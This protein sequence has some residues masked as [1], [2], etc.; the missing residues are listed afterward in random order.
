[1][2]NNKK[3]RKV[4]D[5]MNK[6]NKAR[7]Y[8]INYI[9]ILDDL[10]LD[11][12]DVVDLDD[13][14][15]DFFVKLDTKERQRALCTVDYP[16]YGEFCNSDFFTRNKSPPTPI[17]SFED[18]CKIIFSSCYTGNSHWFEKIVRKYWKKKDLGKL[19]VRY[20]KDK[21]D[22]RR[23]K[24][25]TYRRQIE[26][27]LQKLKS[28]EA[29]DYEKRDLEKIQLKGARR[30]FIEL[31]GISIPPEVM[32][33]ILSYMPQNKQYLDN[34]GV[35]SVEFYLMCLKSWRKISLSCNNLYKIP[36]L[37]LRRVKYIVL[38]TR[39]L[40]KA[41]FLYFWKKT[42]S[43][44]VLR[45]RENAVKLF[46][47]LNVVKVNVKILGIENLSRVS[48]SKNY[49]PNIG[50]FS[51]NS[52]VLYE[53]EHINYRRAR[54][55]M[56][57][58]SSSGDTTVKYPIKPI[59]KLQKETRKFLESVNYITFRSDEHFPYR[60]CE[61]KFPVFLKK[62]KGFKHFR[63]GLSPEQANSNYWRHSASRFRKTEWWSCL[64][65]CK[66]LK[67][68]F[69]HDYNYMLMR[70]FIDSN[71]TAERVIINTGFNID[72]E[73]EYPSR[74]ARE[75]IQYLLSLNKLEF[76]K[77][78]VLNII[79]PS[80]RDIDKV[81]SYL[82]K[83]LENYTLKCSKKTENDFRSWKE[84]FTFISLDNKKT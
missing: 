21:D 19:L 52:F 42:R 37:V 26:V 49:F 5:R 79:Q 78:L 14:R 64:S 82:C 76:C 34:I 33:E 80:D 29:I 17:E 46:K 84:T 83:I 39:K 38:K 75:K 47:Y 12:V 18:I 11:A 8:R 43:V 30:I 77:I 22:A 24:Q 74:Y 23:L 25:M 59:T 50:W 48:I 58:Y 54:S 4:E 51:F 20:S 66:N 7:S 71:Q 63:T 1:M 81:G 73:A 65:E 6:F 62:L 36:L 27:F 41:D 61:V 40:H 56:Y 31:C 53:R 13:I 67:M 55:T 70:Y 45:V 16:L 44:C 28:V 35:L 69:L 2:N 15:K 60:G 9:D 10:T 3:R 32:F 68:I 72:L 57:K